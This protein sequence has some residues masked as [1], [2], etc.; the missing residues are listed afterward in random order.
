MKMWM[1]LFSIFSIF[2]LL[3]LLPVDF[4]NQGENLG[5][6]K[7]TIGNVTDTGRLWAHV[8]LTWLFSGMYLLQCHHKNFTTRDLWPELRH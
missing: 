7:F 5:L 8:I 6:E 2:G 1:I 3:I 4:V